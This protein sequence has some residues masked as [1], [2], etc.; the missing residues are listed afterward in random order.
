LPDLGLVL[1]QW[2][3]LVLLPIGAGLAAMVTARL[4]V[5]RALSRMP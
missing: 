1:W 4:T 5:M 3:A 2:T